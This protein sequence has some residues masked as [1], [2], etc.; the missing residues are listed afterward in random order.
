MRGGV[1]QL[2]RAAVRLVDAA[3]LLLPRVAVGRGSVV[4]RTAAAGDVELRVDHVGPEVLEH[5]LQLVVARL[6]D[7]VGQPRVQIVRP[8]GV[9]GDDLLLA[10]GQAILVVVAALEVVAHAHERLGEAE[11]LLV[12]RSR[13]TGR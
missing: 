10:H 3:D 2:V 8:H 12:V 6:G 1:R 4:E 5:A 9:A 11:V 13:G 7:D